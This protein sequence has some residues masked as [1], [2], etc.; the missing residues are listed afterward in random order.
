MVVG[1]ADNAP[2][3]NGSCA[4]SRR[5]RPSQGSAKMRARTLAREARR[6][7]ERQAVEIDYEGLGSPESA[8]ALI[9]YDP[10]G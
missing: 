1:A 4:A 7:D 10:E 2:R 9:R 3:R 6:T 5:I 8:L